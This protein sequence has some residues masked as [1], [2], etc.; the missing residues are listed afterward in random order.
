MACMGLLGRILNRRGGS[1]HRAATPAPVLVEFRPTVAVV[2]LGGRHDLEVVGESQ[3]Q[4]ALW[5]VAGGRTAER[6]RVEVQ[7]VLHT[8]P[9]NP[10][11]PNAITVLID[12]AKVGYLC[13]DD[14]HAYRPGLLALGTRYQALIALTE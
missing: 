14:A 11:N 10:Y 12:G 9:D 13:R 6:V 8:E 7:A 3:Y 4:D 1:D 2:L 5:R